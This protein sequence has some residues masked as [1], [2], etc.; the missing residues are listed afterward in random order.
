MA[1]I[2]KVIRWL[3]STNFLHIKLLFGGNLTKFIEGSVN[4]GLS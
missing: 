3:T 1:T 2:N 4:E